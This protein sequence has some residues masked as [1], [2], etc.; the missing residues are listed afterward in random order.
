MDHQNLVTSMRKIISHVSSLKASYL[1]VGNLVV[2]KLHWQNKEKYHG[3]I[4]ANLC[5]QL[6]RTSAKTTM[7][8]GLAICPFMPNSTHRC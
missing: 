3:K 8:T 5:E 7:S 4:Q 2:H 6:R 1:Q